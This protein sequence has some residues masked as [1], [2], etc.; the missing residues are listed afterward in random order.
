MAESVLRYKT[1][2][3]FS[4]IM[5]LFEAG[6]GE[7]RGVSEIARMLDM[8]PS[9]VSRVLKALEAEEFVE[10]DP[11]TGRYRVGVRFLLL[12]MV[13]LQNHPLRRI[14]LPHVEQIARDLGLFATWGVFAGDRVVVIDRIQVETTPPTPPMH[15]FGADL[16]LHSSSYGKLLLACLPPEKLEA[17]L[18][19]LELQRLTD[20][21]IVDVEALKAE[22]VRI[23]ARGYAIDDGETIENTLVAAFPIVDGA[24]KVVAAVTVATHRLID[25]ADWE[26]ALSYLGEKAVFI[27]R[28]LGYLPVSGTLMPGVV[29][30][31]AV[32]SG[33]P[34]SGTAASEPAA[35]A[36][37]TSSAGR[38]DQASQAST[39][40]LGGKP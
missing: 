22:L 7:D 17:T 28:Q 31:G 37:S 32:A 5:S 14:I 30:P 40:C 2:A 4:R 27:S 15:L 36:G 39:E 9:K 6:K 1:L 38:S 16:P 12:G 20:R 8:A 11:Q 33:D 3:D 19:T 21:T 18:S 24:S 25:A 13:Y 10:R 23:R 34:A 35:E 29:V 26:H